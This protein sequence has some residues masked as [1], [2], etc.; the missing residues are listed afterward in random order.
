MDCY[1]KV[2]VI[3]FEYPGYG[4]CEGSPNETT[5]N[6]NIRRAFNFL[7][8]DL[9]ISSKFIILFG[10]SIGTGPC[11]LLASELCQTNNPIGGLILQSAYLSIKA[12]VK[13]LVGSVASSVIANRWNSEKEIGNITCPVLMIHGKQDELIHY[14]QSETLYDLCKTSKKHINLPEDADHNKFDLD[15]HIL[16]PIAKFLNE[17]CSKNQYLTLLN[18][19]TDIYKPAEDSISKENKPEKPFILKSML[20]KSTSMSKSS[21]DSTMKFL[22]SKE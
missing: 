14:T 19:P 11:V 3:A 20:I 13:A 22:G 17:D 15:L 8:D 18:L 10:R 1:C 7:T 16:D 4:C 9:Q 5:I 6:Q 21:V 12:V 2:H